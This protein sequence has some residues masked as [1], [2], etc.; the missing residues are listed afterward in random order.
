MKGPTPRRLKRFASRCLGLSGYLNR[1]GDQRVR[2]H[3]PARHLLWAL[4]IAEVLR[5]GAFHA[6]EALVRSRARRGLGVGCRFGDDS[7]AYFTERLDPQRTRAALVGLARRAKR[8][9]AFDTHRFLGLA[10]DGTGACRSHKAGCVWCHPVLTP[11]HEVSSHGHHFSLVTLVGTAL[12]LPLDVEPYGLGDC[13]LGASQRLLERVVAGLGVRFADYVV[14][15]GLYAGAP[16]LHAVGRLGLQVVV[17]LK[18]NLPELFTAA[19]ARF[20]S[21][22]PTKVVEERG[23]R[24]EL[25]DAADFDPWESLQ[26]TTVRVLRYRQHKPGGQVVEAYWLTDWSTGKVGTLALYAMAKSRWQIENEGFNEGKTRHGMERI[27]HHHPNSLLIGWL[28]VCLALSLERL[29]R[30]RHLRR[31]GRAP[32]TAIDLVR[33]LWLNPLAPPRRLD[34]G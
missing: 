21:T 1:P 6:I 19:Q 31:G 11:E 5:E 7:L 32:R 12:V 9:K 28:V 30:L 18:A 2:P 26:W 10:V 4:I 14:A 8:N 22:P 16:F 20:Q 34:T 15:D 24:I 17:R 3:L 27:R 25:W 23:E 29:Y 13:E 33:L